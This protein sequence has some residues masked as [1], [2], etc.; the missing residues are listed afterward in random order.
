MKIPTANIIVGFNKEVMDRLF[1]QGATYKNLIKELTLNGLEDVLLFDNESNP[2][3]ISFEHTLN[4]GS[5]MRM[6]LVLIDPT[7]E[8]EARFFTDNAVRNVVGWSHQRV[9]NPENSELAQK[10][11]E[12]VGVS[13]E[14]YE[15][16]YYSELAQEYKKHYGNKEIFIS[17]GVGNNLDLW[18]GPHRVVLTGADISVK[19]ARKITLDFVPTANALQIGDRRG[20]YNEKVNLNLAGLLMRYEGESKNINFGKF[21]GYDPLN[22]LKIHAGDKYDIKKHRSENVEALQGVAYTDL[23][24]LLGEYDIHAMVVDAIRNYIQKATSNPNVIVLLP[25]INIICRQALQ[26]NAKNTRTAK[27]AIELPKIF[28]IGFTLA[29]AGRKRLF[30]DWV[31]SSFGLDLRVIEAESLTGRKLTGTIPTTQAGKLISAEKAKF[32]KERFEHYYST[33]YFNAVLQ[34]ADKKGIPDHIEV[35]T[36]VINKIRK[37]SKE[38]YQ[39]NF[40]ALSETDTKILDLWSKKTGVIDPSVHYTFGGYNKFNE[41]KEAIIVGDLALI[42]EYLYGGIDINKKYETINKLKEKGAKTITKDSEKKLLNYFSEVSVLGYSLSSVTDKADFVNKEDYAMAAVKEIPLHPLDKI[43]LGNPH[44][45]DTIRHIIYPPVGEQVGSFGDVSYL[46]DE[47]AYSDVTFSDEQKNYIKEKGISVFR[48]NTQNPNI[49]D[50]NFKFGPIY[51][52]LLKAGFSKEITRKAAAVVEG[53]LPTG[54]GSFPIRTRG[55]AAAYIKQKGFT[56]GLGKEDRKKILSDLASRISPNLAR[57]LEL[58]NA[59]LT[60]DHV[61]AILD[62]AEEND[63]KG[64]LAIDQELPGNPHSLTVDMMED[65]YR[66]AL[67][68]SIKT[69]P[70]FHLSKVATVNSP[71]IVFAQDASIK[72]SR[73]NKRTLMNTFFSGLYKIMGFKH[74]ISGNSVQS[75]FKLV[76]NAM[77]M[78]QEDELEVRQRLAKEDFVEDDD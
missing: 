17:Y 19:G 9:N 23:S 68:M 41:N 69:L 15:K 53:L 59:D 51:L 75:E 25:N 66:K 57:E 55:A 74:T 22:Y 11:N 14:K 13:L 47:F 29:E 21:A 27:K 54:I 18:S 4:L 58:D 35:L 10:M 12:E 3:F 32:A 2:N 64:Y 52:A 77:K 37:Q 16:L 31:L 43:I 78:G 42:K 26:E 60:A 67:Q 72:Q 8:L 20:A 36:E 28:D 7:E 76:K 5:S 48:Y 65:L 30:L 71:C 44:Y 45:N 63:L 62:D 1:T 70:T 34:K 39:I 24:V 61:A 73:K 38:E 40:V 49:L 6:R 33:R 46:P 56:Q 50:M